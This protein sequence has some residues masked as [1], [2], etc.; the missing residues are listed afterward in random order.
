MM[1]RDKW[2]IWEWQWLYMEVTNN[3]EHLRLPP[4]PAMSTHVWTEAHAVGAGWNPALAWITSLSQDGLLAVM[5]AADFF[6]RHLAP[7]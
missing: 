6:R 1:L 3:S 5:V 4:G 7:L 2:D